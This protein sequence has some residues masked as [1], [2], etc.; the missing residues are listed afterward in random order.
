MMICPSCK[1]TQP[2]ECFG[3]NKRPRCIACGAGTE[4]L[5]YHKNSG[6]ATASGVKTKTPQAVEVPAALSL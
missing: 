4:P 1:L 6:Q 5:E 2:K 3:Q